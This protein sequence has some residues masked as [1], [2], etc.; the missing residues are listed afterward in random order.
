MKILF[1]SSGRTGSVSELIKN[2]GDSLINESI[3]VNY[4]II[5]PG[6]K[7]YLSGIYKIRKEYRAGRY[8]LIHAH[9]SLSAI[10]ASCAGN[11]PVVASLLG[12]DAF[13]SGFIKYITRLFYRY[14]WKKTIVKTSQM[15]DVLKLDKAEIIPNGVNMERFRPIPQRL[16]REKIG[17]PAEKKMVVFI[18]DPLRPEKN[19]QLAVSTVK[20]L[21]DNSVELVPVFNKPNADIP[22]YLNAAD[23]LLLT[24]SRE[25]SVNV[26]KEALACN[27]PVVSTDVGDVKANTS[28][29]PC[30][31]ICES[32]AESLASGLSEAFKLQRI[33]ESRKRIMDLKLD[34]ESIAE[35][36]IGIYKEAIAHGR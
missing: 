8:D 13:K 36:I 7:G 22:Y 12:S 25:G 32:N 33:A 6:F 1:V 17:F 21:N 10:V 27:I 2:Q 34:S 9:Y 18:S 26:V 30:C 31:F 15:K 35:R 19:F 24:S 29:L 3:D 16:A 5:K 23:V 11:Y 4:L 20:T 28:G 14:R